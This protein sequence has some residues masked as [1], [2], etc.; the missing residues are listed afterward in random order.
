MK[1]KFM[2]L[3]LL[4]IVI[5][6]ASCKKSNNDNPHPLPA[7]RTVK[8][9]LYTTKDFS[10]QS[11]GIRFTLKITANNTTVWDSVMA[12]MQ[13]KNIP[14]PNNK[15]I[16]EKKVPAGN[17]ER[18]VAGFNYYLENVGSSWYMDIIEP[19]EAAKTIDYNF[20]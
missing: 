8:F 9:V 1:K 18:L 14:G 2:Q 4:A 7:E 19:T 5:A 20:Q 11:T 3:S 17:S 10:N 6:T 15:I 16:I 12:P 13:L